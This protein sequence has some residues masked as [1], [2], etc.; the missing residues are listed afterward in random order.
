MFSIESI[1]IVYNDGT[2]PLKFTNKDHK[3]DGM[4]IDIWK[5]WSK[6]T[7]IEVKFIQAPW[8]DTLQMVKDG[9][10][11][12]HGGL[13]YTDERN[14]FL[15]YTTKP[16]YENKNYFF[17]H[18][19]ILGIKTNKDIYPFVVGLG[20]GFPRK[21]MKN[22]YPS[23]LTKA[24][25]S[26]ELMVQ[27]I[28]D[29]KT[30][31]L[32]SSLSSFTFLLKSHNI[33]INDFKYMQNTPAYI[34][35]Y[36]GAVKRGNKLLLQKIN[37]GF[38]LI[39]NTEL[40]QI[41]NKWTDNLDMSQFRFEDNLKF[42]NKEREYISRSKV[43]K[44]ASNP[45][46]PPFDFVDT[47][48]K[49]SYGIGPDYIRL[50]S[51][52]T[53]LKFEFV[54]TKSW[55]DGI[56]NI[57]SKKIDIFSI[58]KQTASRDKYLNFTDN[59]ISFPLVAVTKNDISFIS[60]IEDLKEKKFAM[61]SEFSSTEY[62]KEN[63]PSLD[64]IL[65]K[66]A[67]ECL[68][69]VAN[70]KADVFIGSLGTVSYLL[71]KY[72]YINLKI[73]GEI[74]K[75]ASW[76][77]GLRKGMSPEL[78]SILNKSIKSI[79][80]DQKNDIL[81]KWIT[82]QFDQQVD[83]EIIYELSIVFLLFIIA[84]LYWTRKLAKAKKEITA[85]EI[86]TRSIIENSQDALI[87]IDSNSKVVMWNNAATSI[88]GFT[89]NDMIGNY[90]DVII[91]DQ[92]K[93]LHHKGLKNVVQGEKPKLIGKGAIEIEGISKDGKVIPID[94]VLNRYNI[95]NETFY[96]ANIRDI[97][98]RKAL[99]LELEDEKQFINLVINSQENFVIT[100]DGIHL[101]TANKA[102]LDFYEIDNV[103]DF[104]RIYGNC[105][106]DTFNTKAPVGYIQKIT[107]N[108]KWVDYVHKREHTV[109]KVS[110]IQNNKN[111]IFTITVEELIFKDT[112]LKVAVF[113]DITDM[114]VIKDEIEQIHKHTKESIQY[115]AIIQSTLI[116]D[117][118]LFKDAFDDFFAFWHPKDTV[119]GDVYLMEEL[120]DN[121]DEYLL[122]V[123]DCTGHGVPGAFV[124]MLVR[125][126]QQQI[127]AKIE[128]DFDNKIDISTA[129]ILKYFNRKMKQ[130]LRQESINSI[131]NAGFDGGI[132]Y[133]NKKTN[134]M[135]FSG[136]NTPLFYVENGE[137]IHIKGDRQSVGYKKSDPNYIYKEYIIDVKD[138]MKF[139]ITTDGYLDQNGG[140]KDFP[141]GKK[142]FINIIK[143]NYDKSMADQQEI[144]LNE[145][146]SYQNNSDR[147]DDV[148]VIAFNT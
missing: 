129:W 114:E 72:K 65:T 2:P 118:I 20:N 16:L 68:D 138:G 32:L 34:K 51:K 87:V 81:N 102:F 52:K 101:R 121:K 143:N 115:S 142:K 11:D 25:D 136:S 46:W 92:F 146:E 132:L 141:F 120:R 113:T 36:Y 5:L 86:K 84:T 145:L 33:D 49:K 23:V 134:I 6:K 4:I 76:G 137:V 39:T 61:I 1:R 73:A 98:D 80:V 109:H 70:G 59:Y 8:K 18:K 37:N 108:E 130:L 62:L 93:L 96:S 110:I 60:S 28:K 3:A 66:N 74:S 53:G 63:Y 57:K 35:K 30:K 64:I 88:F 117:D 122:M 31:V 89:Y 50:L 126:I 97:S 9:R 131:S 21:F 107:N 69:L 94:L 27:S 112:S 58:I 95:D 42:T 125:A 105:I 26:N 144:F 127:I 71:K 106:C 147:N 82:I 124:T 12:V 103:D 85:S 40:K 91:P 45:S 48:T 116:P 38:S 10:V 111:Y 22:E 67:K 17:Y 90:I 83:Y 79:S 15:D 43:I 7:G 135:K 44:V 100:T 41:E 77:M 54:K 56:K 24:Y 75:K 13:Y 119:G 104:I 19:D 47:S 78:L 139:Y 148:T 14:K 29:G 123:I 99:M 140:D 55:D 128:H 133:Y